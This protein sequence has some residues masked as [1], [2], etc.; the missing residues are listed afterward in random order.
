MSYF[1]LSKIMLTSGFSSALGFSRTSHNTSTGVPGLMAMPAFIPCEWI[2][3][4]S[5]LGLVLL[6]EIAAGD[7]AAVDDNAAS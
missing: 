2:N 7:S 3:W 4:I 5:S 1:W 6:S